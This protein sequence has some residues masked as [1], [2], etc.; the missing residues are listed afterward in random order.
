M[1]MRRLIT[2]V[3]RVGIS[4]TLQGAESVIKWKG[5]YSETFEVYQG[6]R[7][8]G[9]LSK[10]LYKIRVYGN[11]LFER[12]QM[13]GTVAHIGEISCVATACADDLVELT[14]R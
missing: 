2:R 12:L 7:Q 14:E 13:P 8:G 4:K 9:V 3:T 10:V 11:N 5:A 6:V 1:R